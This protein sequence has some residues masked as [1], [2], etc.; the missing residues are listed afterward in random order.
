MKVVDRD[1]KGRFQPGNRGGPGRP[2]GSTPAARFRELIG[3]KRIEEVVERV[4]ELAQGGDVG[5]LRLLLE[6]LFPIQDAR[7]QELIE[8]MERLES[9]LEQ[10][11]G[12]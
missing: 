4:Y 6:R 12:A 5:A 1:G 8:R 3:Q 7:G 2:R 9:L 10:R 11:N